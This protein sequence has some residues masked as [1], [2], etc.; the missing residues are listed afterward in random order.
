MKPYHIEKVP[1]NGFFFARGDQSINFTCAEAERI[2]K[3]ITE[4][5]DKTRAIL[6]PEEG[7]KYDG[8]KDPE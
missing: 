7:Y 1:G 6:A 4:E 3:Y 5:L 2:T 8:T